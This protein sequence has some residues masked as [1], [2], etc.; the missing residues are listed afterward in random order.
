VK[1]VIVV[2]ARTGSTRLPGKVLRPVCGRP[3]LVHVLERVRACPAADAVILATSREPIDGVLVDWAQSLGVR[4]CQG[5]Q[6]DVVERYCEVARLTEADAVVRVTAD[7]PFIDPDETARVIRAFADAPVRPDYAANVLRRTYPRGLDVDVFTRDLIERL[8]RDA[9]AGPEREHLDLH[10]LNNPER[11]TVVSV[12]GTQDHSAH[13]WTV[14]T[15]ADLDFTQ[16][17]YEHLYPRR[18][19]FGW[20]DVLALVHEH[21]E[22]QA[23]N[24]D[25]KQKWDEPVPGRDR[26]HHWSVVNGQ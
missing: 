6:D 26:W 21:L 1:T 20:R 8:H 14:D 17:V 11:F 7:C 15:Q 22:W 23:L 10:V 18:P 3:M 9:R 2:Q 16:R 19:L 12:E 24:R 5:S 4:A 13:R 25:V